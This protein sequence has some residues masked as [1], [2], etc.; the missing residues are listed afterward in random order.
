MK[1][2]EFKF[3]V[4]VASRVIHTGVVN[5]LHCQFCIAF[6]REDKVGAKRKTTS[7]GQSWV[8]PCWYDKEH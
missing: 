3:R 7:L 5:G 8:A 2:N 1:E 4:S 6:G